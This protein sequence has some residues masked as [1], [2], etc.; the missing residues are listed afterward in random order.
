M[1]GVEENNFEKMTTAV[2]LLTIFNA[3]K[4]VE[5]RMSEL[6]KRKVWNTALVGLGAVVGGALMT[7]S[8]KVFG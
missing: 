7:L 3:V 4:D 6:E 1:N 2:K 5:K 8:K